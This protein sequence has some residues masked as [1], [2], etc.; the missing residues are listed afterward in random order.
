MMNQPLIDTTTIDVILARRK[1]EISLPDL[2]RN[3][4]QNRTVG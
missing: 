4:D 1:A 3:S 2:P